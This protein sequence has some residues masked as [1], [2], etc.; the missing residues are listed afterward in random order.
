MERDPDQSMMRS[1]AI[2][3]G[4]LCYDATGAVLCTAAKM[5]ATSAGATS[6]ARDLTK[7]IPVTRRFD[8]SAKFNRGAENDV[9]IRH[10]I[11]GMRR[12]L[13]GVDPGGHRRVYLVLTILHDPMTRIRPDIDLRLR[14]REPSPHALGL[15]RVATQVIDWDR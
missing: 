11:S 14:V 5:G 4:S 8:R 2:Y 9:A 10:R 6:A 3:A 12:V 13:E 7:R 1:L 15:G